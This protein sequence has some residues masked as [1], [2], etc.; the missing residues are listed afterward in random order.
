MQK[1]ELALDEALGDKKS[2]ADDYGNLGN[3]YRKQ[4]DSAQAEEMY[5]KFIALF[6]EIG[7][8]RSEQLVETLLLEIK[9]R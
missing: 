5:R 8:T 1:K 2:M 3:I 9:K 7:A 4:G 6:K